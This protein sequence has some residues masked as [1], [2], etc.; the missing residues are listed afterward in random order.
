MAES[1][2]KDNVSSVNDDD[3]D[4]K[5]L[6]MADIFKRYKYF[7]VPPD[8]P[9]VKSRHEILE[10]IRN[11][12]VTVLQGET[13]CGKSTQVPQFLL[14]EAYT[15]RQPCNIV[16]TQPRRIA[17]RS[18]AT[19]VCD[20]QKWTV[21][22]VVGYQVGLD[23]K[24]SEDTRIL[25]CTTGVLLEKL[26]RAKS[27]SHYTHI[28]LDEVHDRDQD[29]DFLFIIVRRLLATNSSHVKIILMSASIDAPTFAN[30]FAI[31]RKRGCAPEA[32]PIIRVDAK[33]NFQVKEYYLS[34]LHRLQIVS[35]CLVACMC[36]D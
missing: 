17:A 13:G 7:Y 22:S 6:M 8:L 32:A 10:T 4:E 11:N 15:N 29:M 2:S 14:D 31:P 35:V 1:V 28:I 20:E 36:F 25:F 24:A 30:Y 26:I 19:R 34:D 12:P 9:I 27:M 21:G 5:K 16:V 33:R 18:V 23:T 3:D